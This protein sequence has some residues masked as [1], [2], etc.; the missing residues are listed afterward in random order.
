MLFGILLRRLIHIGSVR[1]IDV[2]GREQTFGNGE[3]PR[4]TLRLHDRT[5]GTSLALRPSS[6]RIGTERRTSTTNGFVECGYSTLFFARLG[7]AIA[8]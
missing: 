8:P 1:L 5:L 4:C 2:Q 6:Y 3:G 7:F